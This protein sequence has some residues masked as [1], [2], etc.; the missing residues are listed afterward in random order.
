MRVHFNR[1]MHLSGAI[2]ER[3]EETISQ[4]RQSAGHED[5]NIASAVTAIGH[6]TEIREHT[7]RAS[8]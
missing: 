7:Q 8:A 4:S 3:A 1:D 2:V 5:R 6:T